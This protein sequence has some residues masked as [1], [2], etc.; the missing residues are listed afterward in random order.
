MSGE[1]H[2]SG[3]PTTASLS[4]LEE[5]GRKAGMGHSA[6]SKRGDKA[7]RRGGKDA[8]HGGKD[9]R[10]GSKGR[11]GSAVGSAGRPVE[12]VEIERKFEVAPEFALPDLSELPGVV[13]IAPPQ[14][15]ELNATYFD[16]PDLRLLR[17]RVTLRRRTGGRDAGWHL[18]LPREVSPGAPTR[19]EIRLPAGRSANRVPAE[20]LARVQVH[21]RGVAP[22]PVVRL[23]THRVVHSLLDER[24]ATLIE[25]ALDQVTA[26]LPPLPDPDSRNEGRG[27]DRGSARTAPGRAD[28]TAVSPKGST[29]VASGGG[30]TAVST[31]GSTTTAASPKG[32][33]PAVP[34]GSSMTVWSELEVELGAGSVELL[35][36]VTERLTAAGAL[37]G[38]ASSKAAHA[39]EGRLAAVAGERSAA[40]AEPPAGTA[41]AVLQAYLGTHVHRLQVQDPLVRVDAEDAVHQM[42]VATRRLRSVLG[43][44]RPLFDRSVT[45]PLRDELA[46][47][48]GVLGAA[49]DLEVIGAHL[50]GL[51][52]TVPPELV[53]GPV[54]NRIVTALGTRHRGAHDDVLTVLDDPRYF[55]LLDALD[56]LLADPPLSQAARRGSDTVLLPLVA[57]TYRRMRRLHERAA[58]AAAAAAA[59][60]RREDPREHDV[61]LHEI[62]KAAKRA[63]YAGEALESRYGKPAKKW[64]SRM[65]DVQE[66]LGV[67]HDAVVIQDHLRR[68]GVVAHLDGENAFTYGILHALERDRARDAEGTFDQAWSRARRGSIH[69]WLR[70]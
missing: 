35:D 31:G 4:S 52:A 64:A 38:A 16:S 10:H 18:K 41:G 7:A 56:R 33:T 20:L 66:V 28:S 70:S 57:R 36:A 47:L 30:S 55:A 15:H 48:G 23:R 34:A 9:A 53:L 40:A 49:R 8:R 6:E 62:R 29:A 63:R 12:V 5:S 32:S 14:D 19:D 2:L 67:H 44:F 22:M 21:L 13:S 11:K 46:W 69:R 65:E 59:G 50:R 17:R 51:V 61:L 68:L 60:A 24:G 58:A 45:D 54:S 43:T 26:T 37:P 1:R 27:A 42:R 39:L 25:I 3:A